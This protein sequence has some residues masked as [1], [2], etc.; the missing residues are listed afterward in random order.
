V[1]YATAQKITKLTISL[2]ISLSKDSYA[3]HLG[4]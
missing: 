4:G 3:C 2:S 1:D